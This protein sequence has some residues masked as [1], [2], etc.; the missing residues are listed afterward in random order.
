MNVPASLSY[1]AGF[2]FGATPAGGTATPATKVSVALTPAPFLFGSASQPIP[3]IASQTN[4][5]ASGAGFSFGAAPTGGTATTA[6]KAS[7]AP[8]PAPLLFGSTPQPMP[9]TASQTNVP[10]SGAGFSF[11]A[12]PTGGMATPATRDSVMPTPAPLLFGS[13]SQPMP[14]NASQTNVPASGSGFSFG[15]ASTGGTAT[16][17]TRDSVA[18]TPGPF[19]FGST[20]QPMPTTASQ[21]NAPSSSSTRVSL[22]F[23]IGTA[24]ST[25]PAPGAAVSQLATTGF[26]FGASAQQAVFATPQPLVFS[27]GAAHAAG[28]APPVVA[29]PN[30]GMAPTNAFSLG[31]GT[32]SSGV[33]AGG[34]SARRCAAKAGCKK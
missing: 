7:M 22:L 12:A 11:G 2:S 8:T 6:K 4:V 3:T 9:T 25:A 5:P 28:G 33:G 10:P 15:T 27:F 29:A 1:G 30:F 13:T 32:S 31:G 34:A 18:P 19:L 16:P 14:N 24:S 26:A 17:V 20:S 23:G 21:T